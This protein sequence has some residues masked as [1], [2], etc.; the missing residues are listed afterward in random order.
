[1]FMR[2]KESFIRFMSG[3]YGT[4]S[5]NKLLFILCMIFL[6]FNLIFQNIILYI[7]SLLAM[8]LYIFRS[9]SKNIP[10]RQAENNK[11]MKVRKKV[12]KHFGV[13]KN[14]WCDRKTHVYRKCPGCK[15]TLR[16]PKKKGKHTC[17]CPRCRNS[18]SVTVL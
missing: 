7:L 14:R 9:F 2:I 13:Y 10:K 1:M 5:L 15:T 16:L 3:R 11:Y 8:V 4:D 12:T 6:I 18:F 17:E